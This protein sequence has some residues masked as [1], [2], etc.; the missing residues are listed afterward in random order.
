MS[1]GVLA[2]FVGIALL[3][4]DQSLLHLSVGIFFIGVGWNF[5]FIPSATLVS[6]SYSKDVSGVKLQGISNFVIFS[7]TAIAALTSG[8]LLESLGWMALNL[9][10][11]AM[12]LMLALL[13]FLFFRLYKQPLPA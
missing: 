1:A 7:C 4:T 2:S 9:I 13:L 6:L 3:I 8:V 11:G 5:I 12:I 10:A